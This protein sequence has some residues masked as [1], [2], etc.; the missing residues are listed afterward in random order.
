MSWRNATVLVLSL[1]ASLLLLSWATD[2]FAVLTTDAARARDVRE[3]PRA[4]PRVLVRDHAGVTHAVL[5][6]V[7]STPET[8]GTRDRANVPVNALRP[9]AVIVDFIY[10]RCITLCSVLGGT[11]QRLQ[12]EILTRGVQDKVRLLTLSFDLEYDD[13]AKLATHARVMRADPAV[14][15]LA[16]PLHAADRDALLETFGVQVIADGVGGWLHNAALH[17]ASPD[18][19]LVRIV[20]IGAPEQALAAALQS[21]EANT[22]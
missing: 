4:V 22:P 18:G 6:D 1:A 16:T 9:R 15:T 12:R 17:V 3:E 10:T 21:W 8:R 2:G 5:D 7:Y 11:Y 20:D 13:P 19:R 14:W